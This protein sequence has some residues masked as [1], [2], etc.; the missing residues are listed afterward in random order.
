MVRGFVAAKATGSAFSPARK[1]S[2]KC[3]LSDFRRR[4]A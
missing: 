1:P 3:S 4:L 2:Q